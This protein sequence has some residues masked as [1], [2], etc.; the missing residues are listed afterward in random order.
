MTI[1]S[2]VYLLGVT[3]LAWAVLTLVGVL[4]QRRRN[5]FVE[6]TDRQICYWRLV[7]GWPCG[8]VEY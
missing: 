1:H 8:V 5:V 7:W 4:G 3:F 2:S 6:F